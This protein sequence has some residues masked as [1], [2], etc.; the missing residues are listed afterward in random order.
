MFGWTWLL[1]CG[2]F[3]FWICRFFI[4]PCLVCG[5]STVSGCFLL[6]AGGKGSSLVFLFFVAVRGGLRCCV[7]VFG[8]YPSIVVFKRSIS[9]CAQFFFYFVLCSVKGL[10]SRL[11][12]SP[13][14]FWWFNFFLGSVSVGCRG[15]ACVVSSWLLGCGCVLG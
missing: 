7:Y 1:A 14:A 11:V 9:S 13:S 10:G 5:R 8:S 15:G 2:W 6:Y 3:K 12:R 4:E